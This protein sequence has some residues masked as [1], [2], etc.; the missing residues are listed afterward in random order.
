MAKARRVLNDQNSLVIDQL[1][2]TVNN[3]LKAIETA[4]ASIDAGA[5]AED[6][7]SALAEGIT[8]GADINPSGLS[9]VVSSGVELV[10]IKVSPEHPARPGS[11][12]NLVDL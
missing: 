8:V 9:D 1:I 5:S 12:D 10:G 6:V 7:L 3:L 4:K 2:S 11:K